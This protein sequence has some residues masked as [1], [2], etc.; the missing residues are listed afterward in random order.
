VSKPLFLFPVDPIILLQTVLFF[1]YCAWGTLTWR[2]I[3][4][5][6]PRGWRPALFVYC[7]PALWVL[8]LFQRLLGK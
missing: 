2:D 7:G 8:V 6:V 3:G 4:P 5:L 1:A